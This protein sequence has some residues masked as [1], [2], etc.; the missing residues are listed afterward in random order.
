MGNHIIVVHAV[1]GT[2]IIRTET[3]KFIQ[4]MVDSVG[5][6]SVVN[7]VFKHDGDAPEDMT[8]KRKE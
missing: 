7:A 4:R 1:G 3:E 8:P 5:S 6:F 2:D